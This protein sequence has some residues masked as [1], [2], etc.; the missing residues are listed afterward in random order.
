MRKT[1]TRADSNDFAIGQRIF[2]IRKSLG[3]T[4]GDV[5]ERVGIS[6]QQVQK[7]EKGRDRCSFSQLIRFSEALDVPLRD[8]LP[9]DVCNRPSVLSAPDPS[10]IR[11]V[12]AFAAIK[13]EAA[14]RSILKVVESFER[15]S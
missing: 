14:R 13:D 4:L 2:S 15:G 7:Y 5:G 10:T 12:R 9:D 11:L 1:K 3:L 6:Y 8:L